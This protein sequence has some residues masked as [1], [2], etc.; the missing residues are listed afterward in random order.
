MG[1]GPA[2]PSIAGFAWGGRSEIY[3]RSRTNLSVKVLDFVQFGGPGETAMVS[4]G[5]PA[6]IWSSAVIA[7][8]SLPA[9]PWHWVAASHR[10]GRL[11]L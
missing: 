8:R 5:T 10:R 4:F 1:V 7:L 2:S 6:C 9:A 11:W 3:C